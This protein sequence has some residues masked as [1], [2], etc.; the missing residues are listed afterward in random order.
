MLCLAT[1]KEF[2]N[3]LDFVYLL[4][5][6]KKISC[7]PA[8]FDGIKTN[9]HFEENAKRDFEKNQIYLYYFEGKCY[10]WISY[11][12]IKEDK[13][14]QSTCCSIHIK[15]YQ[16]ALEEFLIEL[17]TKYKGFQFYFGCSNENV[18]IPFLNKNGFIKIEESFAYRLDF[19]KKDFQILKDEIKKITL[20]QFSDFAVL[21]ALYEKDMYYTS[22]EIQKTFSNWIIYGY[23]Q[24]NQLIAT[25]Y[26]YRHKNL[27]IEIYGLDFK[28]RKYN[29]SISKKLLDILQIEQD[30]P[31][32]CLTEKEE[33][34][35]FEE[36]KFTYIDCY[37]CY[38]KKL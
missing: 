26:A 8:Y 24:E 2:K 22:S 34:E 29:K 28:D 25:I 23:Y 6:D 17:S 32:F 7:Y 31:I 10:G 16:M 33:Q 21:H 37:Q 1:E 35:A 38:M 11:F 20:E 19:P 18:G 14:I 4:S 5:L 12:V 9:K 36:L 27:M 13:Y 30:L 15:Y 3:N